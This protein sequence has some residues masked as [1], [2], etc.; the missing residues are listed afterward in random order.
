MI[1]ADLADL[2]GIET[3]VLNKAVRR[4]IERFPDD[5]MFQLTREEI[6]NLS[7]MVISSKNHGKLKHSPSM[8][9]FTNYGAAML[10]SVLRRGSQRT[11]NFRRRGSIREYALQCARRRRGIQPESGQSGECLPESN[12]WD[13]CPGCA[14]S[15]S[16]YGLDRGPR[17]I[18]ARCRRSYG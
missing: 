2:Y 7:R 1:D 16:G 9:A 11:Q 5:F 3:R 14:G 17:C 18:A 6:T 8:F 10:S 13:A 4:N 15:R 12:R